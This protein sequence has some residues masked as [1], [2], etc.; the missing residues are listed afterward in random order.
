MLQDCQE[1]KLVGHVGRRYEFKGGLAG[2]I[3]A[4]QFTLSVE[5]KFLKQRNLLLEILAEIFDLIG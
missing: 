2:E 3:D 1:Q 4:V 5:A